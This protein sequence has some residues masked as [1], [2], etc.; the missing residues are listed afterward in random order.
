MDDDPGPLRLIT[1]R[2]RAENYKFEGV[3]GAVAALAAAARFRRWHRL[4]GGSR[5]RRLSMAGSVAAQAPGAGHPPREGARVGYPSRVER[6]GE[7]VDASRSAMPADRR[8]VGLLRSRAYQAVRRR[9]V[10][11]RGQQGL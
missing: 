4:L 3:E 6:D 7:L 10:P 9:C 11:A 5:G 8:C 2:L 1:I